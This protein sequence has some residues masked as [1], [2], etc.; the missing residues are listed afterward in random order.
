MVL[1][2]GP[3]GSGKTSIVNYLLGLQNTPWQLNTGKYL[4]YKLFIID[5]RLN[6][7]FHHHN[8]LSGLSTSYPHF[9]LILHGDTF[10][11]LSPTE[12]AADFTF[13]G[14]QKF[15]QHFMEHHIQAFKMPLDILQRVSYEMGSV[16]EKLIL[17]N[18][19]SNR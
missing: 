2:L 8:I 18:V 11:K 6:H 7:N 17:I 15:G 4:T 5:N 10:T 3:K 1:L 13:S 9:T 12:V 16:N 14:L 19:K